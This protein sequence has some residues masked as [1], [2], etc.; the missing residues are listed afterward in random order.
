MKK[1]LGGCLVV[2]LLLLVVG[3]GAV[4]WFVLRPAWNAGSQFMGAATQLAE[5]AQIEAKVSNRAPHQAPADGAITP[6]AWQRFVAVQRSLQAGVGDKL[7]V[8]EARYREIE[9][10]SDGGGAPGLTDMLG[11]Y[12]DLFGLLRDAKQAQVDAL[13]AQG[14][15]LEEYRWIRAQAYAALAVA[16]MAPPDGAAARNAA[17][18]R[19][20]RELLAQTAATAWLGF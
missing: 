14:M 4:W 19:P 5:I 17:L 7:A 20:Q 11:A 8:L 10:R 6:E 12:G 13:N 3:G 2:G 1:A 16:D 9:A 18:V 15:S